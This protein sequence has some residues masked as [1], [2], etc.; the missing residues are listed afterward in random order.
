MAKTRTPGFTVLA[1]GRRL[2][3]KRSSRYG[4]PARCRRKPQAG[5]GTTPDGACGSMPF[6]SVTRQRMKLQ[7]IGGSV[8]GASR[9]LARVWSLGDA[10]QQTHH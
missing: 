2:I 7:E 1:D 10:E 4:R 6:R 8:A 3:D 9:D 5:R